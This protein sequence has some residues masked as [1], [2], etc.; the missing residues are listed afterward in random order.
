MV[1][2]EQ[3]VSELL[4][5]VTRNASFP[6]TIQKLEGDAAFMTAEVAGVTADA[7]ND[8]ARQ[9]VAFMAAFRDKQKEL[10]DK[11]VGG[12]ICTACQTIENLRLKTVMHAGTVLE[13]EVSG[14]TE[15][16]GEPV[17]VA[18]R[19][20]KNSVEGDTHIAATEAVSSLLDFEP[21]AKS[22]NYREEIEDIGT[23][24]LTAYFPPEAELDRRGVRPLTRP[25]GNVE[26]I[27]LFAAR[28]IS[29]VRSG[30]RQFRNLP[31]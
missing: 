7:V 29:R 17:I 19:L 8:V 27:R 30:R 25:A 18:H 23:V 12:C 9:A 16:A 31:A 1:H 13:K 28:M 15:L 5:A 24:D 2:A 20:L 11:S 10:F 21:Y 26:A 4:E 22:R 3:I 6:L 14:L